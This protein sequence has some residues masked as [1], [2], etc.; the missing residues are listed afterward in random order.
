MTGW[1]P[2]VSDIVD[3]SLWEEADYVVKVFL[4]MLA[5]KDKFFFCRGDIYTVAKWAN[6]MESIDEV[7]DALKILSSPDTKKPL[8]KQQFDGRRIEASDGGWFILNGPKYRDLV[9]SF[10]EKERKRQWAENRRQSKRNGRKGGA[11]A[12]EMEHKKGVENGTVDLDSGQPVTS[13]E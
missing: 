8:V 12:A 3:S 1:V 4:S 6:K 7:Q 2:I 11:T 5:K 9:S 13:V 10:K